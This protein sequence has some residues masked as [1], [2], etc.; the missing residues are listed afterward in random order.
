MEN[1]RGKLLLASPEMADPNF[2]K[3]VILM[4]Q[5]GPEGALGLV[6]NRPTGTFV[7]EVIGA[8]GDDGGVECDVEEPLYR[9]GP[10]EGPLMVLHQDPVH[11]EQEVLN[12]VYFASDRGCVEPA[13]VGL[14]SPVRFYAGYAGWGSGQLEGEIAQS[15]WAVMDASHESVF[16]AAESVSGQTQGNDEEE[17]WRSLIRTKSHSDLLKNFNP[18]IVPR[19]PS[20]N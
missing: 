8:M 1:L 15:V 9:G 18:N 11:A 4:V 3:S 16:P 6:L 20:M 13:L 14:V 2:S 17:L 19:D 5:H 7:G 10:C 12:G